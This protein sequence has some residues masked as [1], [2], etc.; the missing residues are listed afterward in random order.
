MFLICKLSP[1]TS[2][3][4]S[5]HAPSVIVAVVEGRGLARGEIGMASIDLKSPQIVLSQFADNTTYAKVSSFTTQK[6]EVIIGA[7]K[8]KKTSTLI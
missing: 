5:A 1:A 3:A 2:S 4:V 6:F 8:K 7:Q